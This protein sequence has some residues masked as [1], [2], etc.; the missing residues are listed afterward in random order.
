MTR[1]L[2]PGRIL[3]SGDAAWLIDE[4][5]P[6]ALA[7]GDD[8]STSLQSWPWPQR[9]TDVELDRVTVADGVGI[10]VGDSP[11]VS[12]VRRDGATSAAVPGH[13]WLAAADPD[14][15]WFVDRSYVH[16]GQPP[17]PPPPSPPGRILA[18]HRDGSR[19]HV[20]APAPVIAIDI[21]GADLIITLAEPPLAAR[22]G[23][24]SWRFHY[25]RSGL[26]VSR[27]G[28]LAN[29]LATST[30]V[31]GNPP[32]AVRHRPSAWAWLVEE[33]DTVI[34][35]G[36]RAAGLAWWAGAPYDGDKIER[37]VVVVGSDP[38]TGEARLRL[39]LGH[40]LVQDVQAIGDELWVAVARRRYLAVPRDRGVDVLAVSASGA[41]RT[42]HRANSI[43]IS[44]FAPVLN[45]PPQAQIDHHIAEV[46]EQF[47]H[48]DAHWR[49]DDDTI[50]PLSVALSDT[51]VLVEGAWPDTRLVVTLRHESRPGLL[52]RRTLPLFDE[53]G[54]PIKHEG[55]RFM[56]DLDTHYLAPAKEAIDGLLDT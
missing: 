46:R 3:P 54:A 5:W 35:H 55:W 14:A 11:T 16:P 24:Q 13:W 42:V 41:V 22:G 1:H 36:E 39:E 12:W 18:V 9:P 6:V 20:D 8:G 37:P 44:H 28:L 33:P 47:E 10:V 48:L 25:P 30:P 40:G 56:E 51:A 29:G 23:P 38:S 50:S 19:T 32:F 27:A 4:S 52:L 49:N 17:A 43:D 31:S 2:R 7:I 21:V 53:T 15:A 45:R 34:R 26:R